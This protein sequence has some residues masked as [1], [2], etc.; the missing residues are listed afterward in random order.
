MARR[1]IRPPVKYAET[2]E[3]E[4][5]AAELPETFLHCREMNHNWRPHKVGRHEDGGYARV[6]RCVRCKTTKTQHLDLVG[7]I[8][9][10]SKYEHPEGYL[11]KGMGR[12]VGEG[13]GKLRL[14]SI[15]RIFKDEEE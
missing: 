14:E 5:F 1:V 8:V 10:S 4:E 7:M 3:V 13:R 2:G 12:I 15:K 11:H 9:G 6:L